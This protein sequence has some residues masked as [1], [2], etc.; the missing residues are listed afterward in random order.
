MF[1]GRFT[2]LGD[3]SRG[4]RPEFGRAAPAGEAQPIYEEFCEECGARRGA[5]GEEMR[6]DL[7]LH[8]PVTVL[9]EGWA[10]CRAPGYGYTRFSS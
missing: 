7:V 9:V 2:L 1:V 6:I 4:T 8:G 3:T 5:F 10:P